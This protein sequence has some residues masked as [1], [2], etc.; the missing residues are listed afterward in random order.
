VPEVLVSNLY[1][2]GHLEYDMV[3]GH[4][5]R[6]QSLATCLG[7]RVWPDRERKL[8]RWALAR[9]RYALGCELIKRGYRWQALAPLFR[10]LACPR[11]SLKAG[12]RLASCA[13]PTKLAAR[14]WP[15]QHRLERDYQRAAAA[16]KRV[17]R[18]GRASMAVPGQSA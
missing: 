8:F 13:L 7:S 17:A 10:A 3:R 5:L 1:H 6:A 9:E 4:Q 15:Y 11:L 14:L 18:R 2:R 16:A 12:L